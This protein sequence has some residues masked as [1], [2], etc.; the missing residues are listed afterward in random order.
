M[1][2]QISILTQPLHGNYGGILQAYALQ[3]VLK[4]LGFNVV[5]INY[6]RKNRGD[7][8]K[9]MGYFLKCILNRSK[10][11]PYFEKEV[12]AI[13]QHQ[14]KFIEKNINYSF[15]INSVEKLKSYIEK[16]QFKAVIVGSDQVWRSE[17]SPRIESFFLDFVDENMAIKK[18]AYAASFGVDY[19][20]FDENKTNLI[21]KLLNTFNYVSVREESAVE[22]CKDNL[23]INVEHVLD[24]T[25]LL[26]ASI[27]RTLC[28]NIS[29]DMK[30]KIFSYILDESDEKNNILNKLAKRCDMQVKKINLEKKK[31]DFF[32]KDIE[33]YSN[34]SVEEWIKSIDEADF[35][36]TDSFH[37]VV[38]SLIF[39]KQFL[40]I[41]NSSRGVS[42]FESLL[43]IF[44]LR[45]RMLYEDD[46]NAPIVLDEIEYAYIN[47]IL[48]KERVKIKNK[49]MEILS[50]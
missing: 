26:N 21:R 37:G 23:N 30:G 50:D 45:G 18:L 36:V 33:N 1:D 24:P 4:E 44:N 39:N 19:W 34:P 9:G 12:I 6:R 32:I 31:I 48:D 16:N 15:E 14:S 27:Y 42:R 25:L 38:F 7:F 2:N 11:Y 8:V 17:Y 5:T 20:E 3:Y 47:T 49:L 40:V 41:S 29:V 43:N 10:E 46:I 35:V 22:L 13:Q 28:N